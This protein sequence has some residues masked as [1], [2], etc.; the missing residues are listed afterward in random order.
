MRTNYWQNLGK[1]GFNLHQK[2]TFRPYE[3]KAMTD[4]EENITSNN[5][6]Q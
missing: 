2:A 1:L 3:T 6:H 4:E 5:M